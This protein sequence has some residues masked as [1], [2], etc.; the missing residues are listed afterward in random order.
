MVDSDRASLYDV[1]TGALNRAVKRNIDRFPEDFC[2]QLT[3]EELEALR[4]QIGISN[5][6]RGGRRYLPY[7]FTEQGVAMLASVLNSPRS[8]DILCYA[9]AYRMPDLGAAHTH[10]R[11]SRHER[12]HHNHRKRNIFD[13]SVVCER[14]D[15]TSS[16]PVWDR[17]CLFWLRKFSFG[18]RHHRLGSIHTR[19]NQTTTVLRQKAQN[20]GWRRV[21]DRLYYGWSCWNDAA[22]FEGRPVKCQHRIAWL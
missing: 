7:V 6:G 4:F 17:A 2:F 10:S 21:A 13:M 18:V 14:C 22:G 3:E 12:R 11:S 19:L 20:I 1:A 16:N 15:E 9:R 8:E 5:K